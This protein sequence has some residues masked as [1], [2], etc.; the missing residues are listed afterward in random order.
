[1]KKKILIVEDEE[2]IVSFI[3]NRLNTD[4]YE[5]DVALD[6]Q[7][8]LFKIQENYY[9]LI[10]LDIMLPYVDGFELCNAIRKKTK[11]TLIIMVSALD[12]EEFKTKAYGYGIDDYIAKPFSAKEL[13]LKIKS[14][15]IRRD[16]LSTFTQTNTSKVILND[17]AKEIHV[18]G[19]LIEFTPSEYFLLSTF[20]RNN[21]RAYS[22]QELAQLIYHNYLGEIDERG[23][24]SH[25]CNIRKKISKHEEKN[26]IK[27][28]RGVGY[29]IDDN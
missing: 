22:R 27:T 16:E 8:A 1:M 9:D 19:N 28:V 21:N 12:T 29:K 18:S 15:L 5:V 26:I 3:N 13:C 7:K 25:I 10:T 4:T 6:G 17:Q 20:V 24:D 11:K 23:I 14:L 2:S